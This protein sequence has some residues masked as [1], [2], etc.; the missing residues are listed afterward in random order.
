M[1]AR[2]GNFKSVSRDRYSVYWDKAEEFFEAMVD[3]AQKRN[4]NAVGLAGVHCCISAT[5]ALLVR[6]AGLR[7]S[8]DSHQDVLGLLKARIDDPDVSRQAKRLG[9]ILSQKNLIEYID[10]SYTEKDALALKT[11][12]ER[13]LDWV[14]KIL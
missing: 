2:E 10:R 5:D 3:A 14:R 7:S 12:V 11:S 4:W 6:R 8:S 9:E 13:Y 1:A